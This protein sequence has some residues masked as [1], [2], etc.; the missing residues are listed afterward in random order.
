MLKKTISIFYFS[1]LVLIPTVLLILPAD[2]FDNGQS[3]CLSVLLFD[4]TCYSCGITRGIQHLIHFD[5]VTAYQF[6]KSSFLVFAVLFFIWLAEI[7]YAFRKIKNVEYGGQYLIPMSSV[8]NIILTISEKII[9][10]PITL[11]KTITVIGLGLGIV[12]VVFSLL[13]LTALAIATIY[14]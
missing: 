5:F 1:G 8:T 14:K 11:R 4:K 7:I 6:N 13:M 12:S 2:Y 3:I 9:K 10:N